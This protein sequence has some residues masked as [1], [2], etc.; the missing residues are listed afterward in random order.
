MSR[1][2]SPR[3]PRAAIVLAA[4]KGTR[5]RSTVPKVLHKLCGISMIEHLLNR[6]Q[7]L[8]LDRT[9]IVVGHEADRI[10]QA[11]A[12]RSDIDFVLQEP[13]LGTGHAVQTAAPAL[14]GRVLSRGPDPR[15]RME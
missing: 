15:S 4:G 5:F 8:G 14:A 13:Q 7:S 11:L 6:V 10:R 9:V 3:P 12:S 2:A 1:G